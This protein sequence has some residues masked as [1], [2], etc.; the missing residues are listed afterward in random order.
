[1]KKTKTVKTWGRKGAASERGTDR[2]ISLWTLHG[3]E[4]DGRRESCRDL[5]LALWCPSAEISVCMCAFTITVSTKHTLFFFFL[6]QRDAW[7]QWQSPRHIVKKH[8]PLPACWH[9]R[10]LT[11]ATLLKAI[12]ISDLDVICERDHRSD[13]WWENYHLSTLSIIAYFSLNFGLMACNLSAVIHFNQ[14]AECI[15]K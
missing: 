2:Q 8:H 12:N 5:A 4:A 14:P 7:W 6:V 13:E 11:Q 15:T 9:T 3:Q 1:M 10:T